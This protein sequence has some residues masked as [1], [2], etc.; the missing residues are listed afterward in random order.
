MIITSRLPKA[1][2]YMVTILLLSSAFAHA[3]NPKKCAPFLKTALSTSGDSSSIP[4]Q[5]CPITH[6]LAQWVDLQKT[7]TF[8]QIRT[9]LQEH[10]NWPRQAA[11]RKQAEKNINDRNLASADIISWFDAYPP[12]TIQGLKAYA[13]AIKNNDSSDESKEKLEKALLT[14]D[15]PGTD[16]KPILCSVF[17]KTILFQ[18]AT[19]YLNREDLGSARALASLLTPSDAKTIETRLKIAEKSLSPTSIKGESLSETSL[20]GIRLEQIRALRKLEQN[21]EAKDLLSSLP[22]PENE[23]NQEDSLRWAESAWTERNII[24]R[25]YLEEKEYQKAYDILQNHGLKKGENFANAEF[26]SGWIALRFLKKPAEAL[27]HFEK[28][29]KGVKS[30]ISL[31]RAQYWI[32][33]T[34]RALGDKEQ[35]SKWFGKAK[36]HMATYYGQQAHKEL[37]GQAPTIKPTPLSIDSQ[38][39]AH[40]N[41]RELV[42]ALHVLIEAGMTNHVDAFSLAIAEG[43]ENHQEQSLLIDLLHHRVGQSTALQIYKKTAKE[44]AP[45]IPTAYPRLDY[46][47]AKTINPA[48]AH[49]IIRQESRFQPD[50]M[51]TAGAQGL[52]QLMPAT[53]ARTTKAHKI[54]PKKLTDPKHNVHVGCLHLKE[55]LEKYNGSMILAAAAYNAGSTAVDKWLNQYGD[56]R[57]PHVDTIDWVESIPYAETRNYVQRIMENYHCY[58]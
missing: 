9:F 57:H 10:P 52:M 49:A 35:S 1:K 3:D 29:H 46:I 27:E 34:H 11:L 38:T 15:A 54:K 24:A 51:S 48:F 8:E 17:S 32:A 45:V 26:L 37:T 31:A 58:Q 13:L 4:K 44:I 53:A 55:L 39:R 20:P 50:A 18:K 5:S 40:F 42:K 28:L 16:L 36:A 21:D 19:Q 6:K 41:Q 23:E 33:K 22:L 12:L 47:P 43:L 25:R 56:P 14:L 7:G 30:P 2:P